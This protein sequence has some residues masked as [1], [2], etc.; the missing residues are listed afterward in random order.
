MTDT[1]ENTDT[2]FET[3]VSDESEIK[4]TVIAGTDCNNEVKYLA[5]PPCGHSD[6]SC[7]KHKLVV[8]MLVNVMH[9]F[10]VCTICNDVNG[11]VEFRPL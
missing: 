3:I 4:C 10:S 6:P 1:L 5:V 2:K 9:G 11:R 8:D 7:A